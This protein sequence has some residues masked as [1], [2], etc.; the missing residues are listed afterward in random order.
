MLRNVGQIVSSSVRVTDSAARY[1]GE[2]IA[3]VFTQTSPIGVSE[4]TDRLRVRLAEFTHVFAERSVQV[5][6]SFGISVCDG[7]GL[8]PSATE[9][10]ER[11]DRALYRA[12]H[13]GR[14]K[15]VVWTPELDVSNASSNE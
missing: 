3:I 5:T 14:N 13:T 2:E 11:A 6:A 8:V 1:G 10:V 9:I 7:R 15:V 12:K 4:V